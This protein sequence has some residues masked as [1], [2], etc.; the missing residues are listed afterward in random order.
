MSG[1]AS[2]RAGEGA[3]GVIGACGCQGVLW[4]IFSH[5]QMIG[6]AHVRKLKPNFYTHSV[7]TI[8]KHFEHK[9]FINVWQKLGVH[10][11]VI[12][13]IFL[14]AQEVESA[15]QKGFPQLKR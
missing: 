15:A 14:F 9:Y 11:K 4:D 12:R 3:G 5:L 13:L 1:D 2:A 6:W 7:P 10:C 8:G